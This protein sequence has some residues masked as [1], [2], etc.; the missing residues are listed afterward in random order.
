VAAVY[1]RCADERAR[2]GAEARFQ[3]HCDIARYDLS[4]E[5]GEQ[6]LRIFGRQAGSAVLP[7]IWGD[8]V[9]FVRNDQVRASVYLW[10]A[11][12]GRP[13]R[14]ARGTL[15]TIEPDDLRGEL[16]TTDLDLRAGRVLF[17]WVYRPGTSGGAAAPGDLASELW[18]VSAGGAPRRVADQ[19]VDLDVENFRNVSLD[20]PHAYFE[21]QA[22]STS[23]GVYRRIDLRTGRRADSSLVRRESALSI[24]QSGSFA[25]RSLNRRPVLVV[26][27][28]PSFVDAGLD[29]RGPHSRVWGRRRLHAARVA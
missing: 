16:G 13:R 5:R 26:R 23:E 9:A 24:D 10:R 21:A 8:E 25:Y 14:L 3:R 29:E 17:G 27:S 11:G 12:R 6:R 20:G 2:Y 1:S 28:R 4:D 22:T 19:R 18:L 15:G 7:A